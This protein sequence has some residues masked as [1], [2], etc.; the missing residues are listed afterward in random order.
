MGQHC[1]NSKWKWSSLMTPWMYM[2]RNN[3]NSKGNFKIKSEN[4][5]NGKILGMESSLG[6]A[7]SINCPAVQ[8]QSRKSCL[9]ITEYN[10]HYDPSCNQIHNLK[11]PK[12]RKSKPKN[13]GP[14]L[15]TWLNA[16][17]HSSKSEINNY[18]PEQ[19]PTIDGI[20]PI[21]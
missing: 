5:N 1:T 4:Q 14:N 15:S 12:P 16:P 8:A 7:E 20:F 17:T 2:Q 11:W 13:T 10:D 19:L 18:D 9:L 6:Q 3:R 21:H